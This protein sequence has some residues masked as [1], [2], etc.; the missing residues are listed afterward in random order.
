MARAAPLGDD[1]V[2]T[3]TQHDNG[4]GG[5][6]PPGPEGPRVSGAEV[7]DVNRLRRSVTDRKIAGVAGGI[8]RHLDI[9][10]TL[11]RVLLVV[12][13]FFGGAGLLIYGAV[14]LFV[15]AE[16]SDTAPVMIGPETRTVVLTVAL[17]LAGVLLLGNGWWVGFNDGWPAPLLPLVAV[18]LVVWLVLRNRAPRAGSTAGSPPPVQGPPPPPTAG[19]PP[20]Q[21]P[22]PPQPP[23]APGARS[24]FGITMAS[25]LVALGLVATV[26]L[27]EVALPWA[28]YPAA[29]LTV[30]GLALVVGAFRGRSAGLGFMGFVAAAV[31]AAAALAPNPSF[32]D[33]QLRPVRS[34][35]LQ[36]SYERTA[37]R[38]HLDLTG[39]QDVAALNGRV[40]GVDLR[41]GEVLVEV[42]ENVDVDVTSRVQNGRLSILGRTV[43]GHDLTN[44]SAT[45]DTAAPDLRIDIDLGVGQAMVRTP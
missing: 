44:N 27:L 25:V 32:G 13:A 19:A 24:L 6:R 8:G 15:P 16:G 33:V 39:I 37:G 5:P 42:P 20:Y 21:P 45:P 17:V 35:L 38:I 2:M 40:L 23:R 14:W 9:D 22:P 30:I 43:A 34:T 26:E 12:L 10:P 36:D 28:A 3:E 1:R 18:G 7:R 4:P 11:V 29:A 31:L 41:A